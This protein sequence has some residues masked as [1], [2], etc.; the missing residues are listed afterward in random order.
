PPHRAERFR[1]FRSNQESSVEQDAPK[2][3]LTFKRLR[4]MKGPPS[5][6]TRRVVPRSTA[7][8]FWGQSPEEEKEKLIDRFAKVF[9]FKK[10]DELPTESSVETGI[11]VAA[12]QEISRDSVASL[13]VSEVV[14]L[15]TVPT[16]PP[17]LL[18]KIAPTGSPLSTRHLPLVES[19]ESATAELDLPLPQ[20]SGLPERVGRLLAKMSARE[21]DEA[22]I[23]A[24]FERSGSVDALAGRAVAPAQPARQTTLLALERSIAPVFGAGELLVEQS[25]E[26][27]ALR[28]SAEIAS[29][30]LEALRP[31]EKE[32]PELRPVSGNPASPETLEKRTD[33][34]RRAGS[35]AALQNSLGE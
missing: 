22:E 14:S 13:A 18:P 3:T 5:V 11:L 1:G 9:Q 2:K 12:A 20:S 7:K 34:S 30:R 8:P 6:A 19:V 26:E 35:L 15:P 17:N 24:F 10:E 32:L 28:S 4:P 33:A 21:R 29:E 23:R 27:E 31:T 25:V 16:S